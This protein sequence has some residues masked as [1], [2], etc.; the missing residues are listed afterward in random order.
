MNPGGQRL[1]AHFEALVSRLHR[2]SG[3]ERLGVSAEVFSS[4][5]E[6]SARKRFSG[7]EA[8]PGRLE[9]YFAS[10][11]LEDLALACACAEGIEAAWEEFVGKYRG[12]LRSASAAI[13]RCTA[14]AAEAVELADSLFAE[15]YG[16]ADGKRGERSLF[17][18]FHGR[19]SLKT[20][21]RAVLAQRRVNAIRAGKRFEP[22][23]GPDGETK[24][25][26]VREG[27]SPP[28]ALDPDRERYLEMFRAA[29]ET[30][31]A[32]LAPRDVERLRLYYGEERT[33]AEI[34]KRIG[35]HESSVS[36][37][38]ERIR[39]ELREHVEELLRSG[40]IRPDGHAMQRGLS[41]AQIALCFEYAT[42]ETPIDLEKLFERKTPGGKPAE[43]RE[44]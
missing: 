14:G 39:H 41:E 31:L 11:H 20:W 28:P 23:E 6:R 43:K 8:E 25:F 2:E 21:L 24:P 34:G 26:E 1:P 7:C 17:R 4:T 37:N 38:L 18:Y 40:G 10:L 15:L 3:A 13:L 16:L 42:G 27:S 44:P 29:L 35:E 33:L 22:L 12:Y 9:E 19:S 36:R 30:A 32:R 5:L